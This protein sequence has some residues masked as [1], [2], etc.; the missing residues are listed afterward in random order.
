MYFASRRATKLLRVKDCHDWK[1]KI[2]PPRLAGRARRTFR[3]RATPGVCRGVVSHRRVAQVAEDLKPVNIIKN[4]FHSAPYRPAAWRV[5]T[6][7]ASGAASIHHHCFLYNWTKVFHHNQQHCKLTGYER[8]T[9]RMTTWKPPIF[10]NPLMISI[11][12][13]IMAVSTI[14]WVINLLCTDCLQ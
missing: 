2:R 5:I 13:P 12:I 6:A 11:S 14:T 3:Q 4:L 9:S 10:F 1:T 7:G 8:N